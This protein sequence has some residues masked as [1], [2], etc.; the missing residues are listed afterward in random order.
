MQEILTRLAAPFD[1]KL[2][3]WGVTATNKE[4]TNRYKYRSR[5]FRSIVIR[6]F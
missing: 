6:H 5:A 3:K 2:V 1:L 4:K